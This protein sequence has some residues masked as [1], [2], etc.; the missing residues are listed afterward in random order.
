MSEQ[1]NH[2]AHYGG[3]D[4]PYEVIKVIDAWEL[5]FCLG[6][7]VKYIARHGKKDGAVIN[8]ALQDLKKAAWY[9]NHEIELI[10]GFNKKLAVGL[11]ADQPNPYIFAVIT[12][13]EGPSAETTFKFMTAAEV[14]EYLATNIYTEPQRR[15]FSARTWRPGDYMRFSKGWIFYVVKAVA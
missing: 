10:E 5:N 9:L 7:T 12:E 11:N 15:S 14:D 6:N 2:P 13:E 8:P 1:V 4:N 3:A